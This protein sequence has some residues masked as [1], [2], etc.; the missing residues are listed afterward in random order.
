MYTE[1]LYMY[2]NNTLMFAH[3]ISILTRHITHWTFMHSLDHIR[4]ES[5]SEVQAEQAHAEVPTNLALDQGKPRCIT[6]NDHCLFIW[7]ITLY[8]SLIE[9]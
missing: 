6:T 3:Y 9:H 1:I 8:S 5:D 4:K 2:A 7:I